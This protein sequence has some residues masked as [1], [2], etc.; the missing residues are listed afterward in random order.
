MMNE[1]GK[2]D[3]PILPEKLPNKAETAAEAME[4]RG[5]AKGNRSERNALRTQGRAGVQSALGRIRQA[6]QREG[7]QQFTAL[8][9]HVYDLDMLREGFYAL[10][11]KQV[12]SELRGRMHDPIPEQGGY[13][14]SVIA[15]HTRYYGVPFNS[16]A[17]SIFRKEVCRSWLRV[18]RRRSHKHRLT[19]DRMQRLIAKWIPPARVCHPHPLRRFGVIT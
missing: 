3:N 12:R 10:K 8:Y 2:S 18:L 5:L 19:W 11:L 4:E 16:P 15:G 7:R 17:I 6:A 13:L 14:Q 9:H 1:R